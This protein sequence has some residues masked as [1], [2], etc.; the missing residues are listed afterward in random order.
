MQANETN[1]AAGLK[2]YGAGQNIFIKA[3]YSGNSTV[4]AGTYNTGSKEYCTEIQYLGG[5]NGASKLDSD[6]TTQVP[7]AII[8][9]ALADADD[10]GLNTPYQGYVFM[11]GDDM[12]GANL[13]YSYE[14]VASPGLYAKSGTNT[15]HIN[16]GGVVMMRDLASS[17]DNT[18]TP[19]SDWVTP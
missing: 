6:G 17:G 14:A 10:T 18:V 16:T 15:F 3:N 7:L 11:D 12:G 1:A 13:P 2:E 19:D 5:T 9:G 8:P 4:N